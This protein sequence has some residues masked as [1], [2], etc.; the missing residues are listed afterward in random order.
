MLRRRGHRRV[1]LTSSLTP[2]AG[3]PAPSLLVMRRY[4]IADAAP[5]VKELRPAPCR[6]AV[7][8]SAERGA[9]RSGDA[10]EPLTNTTP[11]ITIVSNQTPPSVRASDGGTDTPTVILPLNRVLPRISASVHIALRIARW[12]RLHR[13]T[14]TFQAVFGIGKT[15]F[16][17]RGRRFESCHPDYPA[18]LPCPPAVTSEGASFLRR[19]APLEAQSPRQHDSLSHLVRIALFTSRGNHVAEVGRSALGSG[20]AQL[21]AG[22]LD[23][24]RADEACFA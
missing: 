4:S 8:D 24:T 13:K 2:S 15:T 18:R 7:G 12:Y 21:R 5:P 19:A 11:V 22:K 16:G 17:R 23:D 6:R 9:G 3:A 1:F 20:R 14:R 10:A